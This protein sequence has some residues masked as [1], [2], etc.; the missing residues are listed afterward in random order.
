[1]FNQRNLQDDFSYINRYVTKVYEG[2]FKKFVMKT[3][4][5]FF[6][7]IFLSL[8]TACKEK[9]VIEN[10]ETFIIEEN[11]KSNT[12]NW[13]N[14]IRIN[15]CIRLE[16]N[17]KSLLG[18][19]QKVVIEDNKIFIQDRKNKSLKVFSEQGDF[20]FDIGSQGQG[21]GEYS[22][23]RD[24]CLNLKQAEVFILDYGKI[25]SY[26]IKTGNFLKK[27]DLDKNIN[28]MRFYWNNTDLFYLWEGNSDK[29]KS[30]LLQWNTKRIVKGF[31]PY[32]NYIFET[33]RFRRNGDSCLVSPPNGDFHIYEIVK[34]RF[35][36]KYYIDFGKLA[37]PN[38]ELIT[39]E[40]ANEIYKSSYIHSITDV[41][42]TNQ[43]LFL[44]VIGNQCYHKV[45]IN[46]KS[47]EVISGKTDFS[48]NPFRV[49]YARND[50]FYVL[51]EPA[52][53]LESSKES[54]VYSLKDLN[55]NES[56]NPVIIK[57][58]L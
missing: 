15:D 2:F 29:D 39:R 5:Y 22:E 47:K 13:P 8:L 38:S 54:I 51:A 28:P 53:V 7:I 21:P 43:W 57:L 55:L 17:E 44:Y 49:V 52:H 35:Y 20:L 18:S 31:L 19:I 14:S 34:D 24:F 26:D 25:L 3:F 12:F 45:L 41:W 33:E 4:F 42:E 46:K 32:R 48:L 16:T 1:M 40:N 10:C 9:F 23:L 30:T 50:E 56:D 58:S 37:L 6:V 27:I 11:I 36:P